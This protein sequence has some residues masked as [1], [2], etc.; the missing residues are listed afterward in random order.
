MAMTSF[1][2]RIE[3]EILHKFTLHCE[4]KDIKRGELLRKLIIRELESNEIKAITKADI[5]QNLRDAFTDQEELLE[6]DFKK[7]TFITKL[8]VSTIK[9]YMYVLINNNNTLLIKNEIGV[10]KK[11]INL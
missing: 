5:E 8:G 6:V 10:I 3:E 1:N 11:V 2:F 4:E 7:Q 9:E